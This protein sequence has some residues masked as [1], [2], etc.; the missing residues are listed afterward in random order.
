MC[1]LNMQGFIYREGAEFYLQ[2]RGGVLSTGGGA[3][4][5]YRGQGGLTRILIE[6]PE[7]LCRRK[8]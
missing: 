6:T 4:F 8:V 7:T 3:G 5:I 1:T 2:G